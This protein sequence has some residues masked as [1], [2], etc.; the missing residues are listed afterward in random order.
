MGGDKAPVEIVKG[1]L[2]AVKEFPDIEVVLVGLQSQ[3][4]AELRKHPP[5]PRISI[6]P[7]AEVISMDQDDVVKEVKRRPEAS[8][9]VAMNLVKDGTAQAMISAGNTGAVMTSAF[10]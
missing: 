5:E 7:A 10:F 6:V 3:V 2:L 8:I 4:E 9:N 1:A